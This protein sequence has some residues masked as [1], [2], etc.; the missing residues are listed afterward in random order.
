VL[1]TWSTNQFE[2]AKFL[3]YFLLVMPS[4]TLLLA[5]WPQIMFKGSE[6]TLE[7]SPV[8]WSTQIGSISGNCAWAEVSAIEDTLDAVIITGTNGNA[9]VIPSRAFPDVASRQ[10]FVKYS[11]RWHRERVV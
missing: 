7:V 11:Q 3:L 5:T 10:E 9:L 6:R 4:V 2:S 8:G 1:T